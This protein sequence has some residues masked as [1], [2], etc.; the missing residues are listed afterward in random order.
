[1]NLVNGLAHH[2]SLVAQWL[3]R[4]TSIWKAMGSIAIRD[5]EFFLCSMLVTMNSLSLSKLS[6]TGLHAKGYS[7][8]SNLLIFNA[9]DGEL[10][11][12]L[13]CPDGNKLCIQLS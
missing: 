12:I 11:L 7:T 1:M 13:I 2:K 6:I 5:S 8:I 9:C 3:E 10:I 4:P